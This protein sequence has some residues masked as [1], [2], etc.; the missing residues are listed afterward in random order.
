[1]KMDVVC[2]CKMPT[3]RWRLEKM[4]I[5]F[6]IEKVFTSNCTTEQVRTYVHTV[7]TYLIVSH[8]MW[9]VVLRLFHNKLNKFLESWKNFDAPGNLIKEYRGS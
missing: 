8:P 7:Y 5:K 1:M 6:Y 2:V 9:V 3:F 4:K